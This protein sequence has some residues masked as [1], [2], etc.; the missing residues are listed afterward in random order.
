MEVGRDD[1]RREVEAEAIK[2]KGYPQRERRWLK[3][4]LWK[5]EG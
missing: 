5:E 1:G 3:D 2:G 4:Y